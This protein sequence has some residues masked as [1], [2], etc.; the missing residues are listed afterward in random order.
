MTEPAGRWVVARGALQFAD[1]IQ[2]VVAGPEPA[3]LA[4][5]GIHSTFELMVCALGRSPTSWFFLFS[6]FLDALYRP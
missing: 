6:L 2:R 3:G 4:T 5:A 1:L